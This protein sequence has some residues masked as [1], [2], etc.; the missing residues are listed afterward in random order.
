MAEDRWIMHG[1]D[2]DDPGCIRTA[3]QLEDYIEQ[4]GFLPLFRSDIPGFSVEEHVATDAWW[5]GDAETDPWEWRKEIATGRRIAYGKFFGRKAGFISKEWFPYFAN[6]R[7]EGYD[8]DARWEDEL[9]SI[10]SKKI[11]DVYAEEN[12]DRELFSSELKQE[13][14]LTKD[15]SFDNEITTLQMQTYLCIGGFKRKLNKAGNEYGWGIAV[16]CTPEHLWGYDYVT[17]LYSEDPSE[18]E[19]RLAAHLTE[20]YP[21]I[22]EIQIKSCLEARYSGKPPKKTLS[23]PDNLVK[24]LKMEG[25]TP[26]AATADQIAGLIVALGQLR[27]KH[28]YVIEM[29]YRHSMNYEQIGKQLKRSAGTV[30]GYHSK[31]LG[32]LRWPE[33]SDW[34]LEG[35]RKTSEKYYPEESDSLAHDEE[36]CLIIGLHLKHFNALRQNGIVTVSDLEKACEKDTWYKPIKGIG[37][38][39]ALEIKVK[40]DNY[41]NRCLQVISNQR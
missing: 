22:S 10:R 39:T 15:K 38:K 21:G 20:L 37:L 8:F 33:I 41:K 34:Y 26:D 18:S 23:Y 2:I 9:A 27:S 31:A 36:L 14:N 4:V 16:Y 28:A 1:L 13:A 12:I 11:M 24:A 6:C 29:K 7:R 17:S 5:T 3:A 35:Y 25:F 40:L 32:K 30:S 19:A